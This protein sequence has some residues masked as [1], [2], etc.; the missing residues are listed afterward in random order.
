[1]NHWLL[2]TEP[3]E[4]DWAT[5]VREKSTTWDGVTNPQAQQN[6]RA[7]AKGDHC[8]LYHTG[9][10]RRIVGIA[11]VT[12]GP[13]PDPTDEKGKR[14]L[15][16]IKALKAAG[17]PVSLTQIKAERSLQHLALLKQGRLS[18]VP[19]DADAWHTLCKLADVT[20]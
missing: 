17:E 9:D 5:L 15:I 8:F 10:E 13:Y 7:M 12:R 16:D 3:S 19:I 4:Y 14:V 1:M 2:K 18:V 11:T 6:L 20:E